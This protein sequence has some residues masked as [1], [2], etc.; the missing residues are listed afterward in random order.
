M[1]VIDL[2]FLAKE[3]GCM[4]VKIVNDAVIPG[5]NIKE[6]IYADT[7]DHALSDNNP[8]YMLLLYLNYKSWSIEIGL[9]LIINCDLRK[10]GE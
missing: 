9:N 5:T 8:A 10:V 2:L 1:D 7:I 6:L 4:A 3:N